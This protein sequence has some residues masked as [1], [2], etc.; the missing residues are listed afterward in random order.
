M[1][2]GTLALVANAGVGV[3]FGAGSTLAPGAT[4]LGV[5]SAVSLVAVPEP[6]VVS[7]VAVGLA[8]GLAA[9]QRR[10]RAAM[11]DSS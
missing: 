11:R 1:H 6:S 5:I 3:V 7:L 10:I 8:A 9:L 2:A 4:N